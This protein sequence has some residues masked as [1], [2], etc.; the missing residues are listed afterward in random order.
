[1]TATIETEQM[2]STKD[3]VKYRF[4]GNG[5]GECN[6]YIKPRQEWSMERIG[7]NVQLIR[8]DILLSIPFSEFQRHWRKK[9]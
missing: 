5:K 1:M 3:Y 7:D 8:G 9:P 2:A 6:I 4:L